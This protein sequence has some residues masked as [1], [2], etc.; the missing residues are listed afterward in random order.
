MGLIRITAAVAGLP[1][2]VAGCAVGQNADKGVTIDLAATCSNLGSDAITAT[3]SSGFTPNGSYTS[4]VTGPDNATRVGPAG[5][6]SSTGDVPNW[7]F[8]CYQVPAGSYTVTIVDKTSQK[9]A[10]DTFV[11]E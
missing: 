8:D 2:C 9:K 7:R 1:F 4:T 11:V 3:E 6:A 10:T 5:K